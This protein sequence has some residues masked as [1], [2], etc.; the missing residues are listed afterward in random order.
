MPIP[1]KQ[2]QAT[3]GGKT[4]ANNTSGHISLFS[5]IEVA[6]TFQI[7]V[8]NTFVLVRKFS[9]NVADAL[10]TLLLCFM[11][12]ILFMEWI[13]QMY[14]FF[15]LVMTFV[16]WSSRGLWWLCIRRRFEPEQIAMY[17]IEGLFTK[18][19]INVS[20]YRKYWLRKRRI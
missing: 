6:P 19:W 12:D 7:F 15:R 3:R 9:S 16:V 14:V 4:S 8:Q 17:I 10:L 1:P 20:T 13:Y 2:L 11:D 5:R 18:S